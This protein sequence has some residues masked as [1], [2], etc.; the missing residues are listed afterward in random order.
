MSLQ[1]GYLV[2]SDVGFVGLAGEQRSIP[3]TASGLKLALAVRLQGSCEE[4]E[5]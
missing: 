5:E 1:S 4:S 3:S 2:G